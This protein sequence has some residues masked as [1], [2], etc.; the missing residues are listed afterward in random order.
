MVRYLKPDGIL[1]AETNESDSKGEKIIGRM[2]DYVE[3]FV[4]NLVA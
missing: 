4:R 2:K 3:V 1:Y